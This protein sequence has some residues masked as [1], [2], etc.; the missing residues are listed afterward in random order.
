MNP[1]RLRISAMLLVVAILLAACGQAPVAGQE[2]PAATGAPVEAADG[3]ASGGTTNTGGTDD[4]AALTFIPRTVQV[5][6]NTSVTLIF[7]NTSTQPHNLQIP[8]PIKAKTK[9]VVAAGTSDTITFTTSAPGSI[10]FLC[11]FH[12]YMIGTLQVK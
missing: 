8:P 11:T 1:A 6:A 9:L 4:D 7:N 10:K 12:E 3:D 5:P 2:V